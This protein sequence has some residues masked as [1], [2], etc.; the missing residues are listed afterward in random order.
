MHEEQEQMMNTPPHNVATDALHAEPTNDTE[1]NAESFE[2][3]SRNKQNFV[4]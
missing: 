4:L 2:I 3:S 1:M